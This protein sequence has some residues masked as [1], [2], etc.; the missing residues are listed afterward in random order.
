MLLKNG[1]VAPVMT[2]RTKQDDR[3]LQLSNYPVATP[4]YSF[5]F[6]GMDLAA[7]KKS[8]QQNQPETSLSVHLQSLWYDAKGDWQTAHDLIDKLTDQK[9]ARLHAYLHRKEG[10]TRNA[11]YWYGKAGEKRPAVSLDEE[12]A[13]L[14][15]QLSQ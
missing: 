6:T 5:N 1:F 3:I 10:D 9:S 15:K 12:W 7:F 2:D 4:L 11:D 8:L 13:Y 14:V